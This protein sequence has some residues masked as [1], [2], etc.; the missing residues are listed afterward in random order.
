MSLLVGFDQNL[1]GA[2]PDFDCDRNASVQWS[3]GRQVSDVVQSK[4]DIQSSLDQSPSVMSI[5]CWC[6]V[7][8]E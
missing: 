7:Q 1:L 6:L 2:Y 8:T 4:T 5:Q 3:G